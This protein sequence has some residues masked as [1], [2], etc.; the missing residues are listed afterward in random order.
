MTQSNTQSV[1]NKAESAVKS[2]RIPTFEEVYAMPYV[3]ES[4][5]YILNTNLR[6]YPML[7]SYADDIRQDILIALNAALPKYDGRAGLN[8][9]CRICIENTSK[10]I[11]RNL[12]CDEYFIL[13]NA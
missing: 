10:N 8:T 7:A 3:Q 9:F 4:I 2:P 5:D 6:K 13:I 11:V 12:L 1:R